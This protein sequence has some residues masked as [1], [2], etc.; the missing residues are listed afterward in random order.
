VIITLRRAEADHKFTRQGAWLIRPARADRA[1]RVTLQRGPPDQAGWHSRHGWEL[2]SPDGAR[3]ALAGTLLGRAA[4]R[5]ALGTARNLPETPPAS[6]APSG[7]RLSRVPGVLAAATR[8]AG[9]AGRL[10]RWARS[11]PDP[12]AAVPLG[13]GAHG[14]HGVYV[15]PGDESRLDQ[16][17]ERALR[18]YPGDYT[19]TAHQVAGRSDVIWWDG[20]PVT[21]PQFLGMLGRLPGFA[22][23]K[24]LNG[25]QWPTLVLVIRDTQARGGRSFAANVARLYAGKVVDA[26]DHTGA[27][28]RLASPEV[29]MSEVTPP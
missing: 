18:T 8:R 9:A 15:P 4:V 28:A 5:Q 27:M 25:G 19:V 13:Q 22:E 6:T 14:V 7:D 2:I 21:A 1:F 16:A 20:R 26:E 3:H 29:P 23:T 11:V 12:G 10:W 24:A 17:A